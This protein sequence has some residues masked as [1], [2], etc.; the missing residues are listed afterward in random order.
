V[1]WQSVS[2]IVRAFVEKDRPNHAL[3]ALG[4]ILLT[5]VILV[6]APFVILR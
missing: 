1:K 5:M 3:I 6:L 2:E 4:L